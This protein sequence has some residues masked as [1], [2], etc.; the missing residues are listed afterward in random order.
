MKLSYDKALEIKLDF[1]YL[2]G[3]K[4]ITKA[5]LFEIKEIVILPFLDGSFGTF[6]LHYSMTV[7]KENF[8]N[9]YRDKEM[10]LLIYF[11]DNSYVNFFQ[12]IQDN[13]LVFDVSKYYS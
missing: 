5:D 8:I 11:T 7:D 6:P 10:N 2:I 12:Y 4:F 13:N 9:P 1:S 3:Q